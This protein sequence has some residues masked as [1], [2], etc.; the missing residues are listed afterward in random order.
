MACPKTY[1]PVHQNPTPLF[2]A[3]TSI[4]ARAAITATYTTN[5]STFLVVE[6]ALGFEDAD[7]LC[8]QYGA[9]THSSGHL[10]SIHSAGENALLETALQQP[11]ASVAGPGLVEA[12]IGLVIGTCLHACGL[13]L[14]PA[15]MCGHAGHGFCV[16]VVGWRRF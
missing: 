14:L 12:W 10:A 6:A 9:A 8:A 15:C 4:H 3:C 11:F 2:P 13:L 5:T 1:V 7:A 16:F